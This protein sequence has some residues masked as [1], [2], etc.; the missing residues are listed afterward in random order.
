V[1]RVPATQGLPKWIWGLTEI[2]SVI[3]F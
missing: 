3:W 2:L 1:I